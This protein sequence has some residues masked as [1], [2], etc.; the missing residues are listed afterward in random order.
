MGGRTMAASRID[1]I[2][3]DLTYAGFE[4]DAKS[5]QSCSWS[6]GCEIVI[7]EIDAPIQEIKVN[8]VVLSGKIYTKEISVDIDT[9]RD[10]IMDL[11]V[12]VAIGGISSTIATSQV[13]TYDE[14]LEITS[15]SPESVNEKKTKAPSPSI[16][17]G[18]VRNHTEVVIFEG[19][20]SKIQ[21]ELLP[22]DKLILFAS[23]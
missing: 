16:L 12:S 15:L 3:V 18:Y 22:D 20:L 10:S 4:V 7:E 9:D 17:L 2:G 1:G 6:L 13:S 8:D 5:S 23:H 21:V 14:I 19:D 11:D